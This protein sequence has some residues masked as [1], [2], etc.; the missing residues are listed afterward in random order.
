MLFSSGLSIYC[1]CC[2]VSPFSLRF[3]FTRSAAGGHWRDPGREAGVPTVLSRVDARV[4][5]P[6]HQQRGQEVLP[7]YAG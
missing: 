5:R 2:P 6:T 1:M 4:P 3:F 7:H